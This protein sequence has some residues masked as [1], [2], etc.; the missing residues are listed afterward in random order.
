MSFDR[1]WK[2][3]I[4]QED[5]RLLAHVIEARRRL[6]SGGEDAASVATSVW[7]RNAEVADVLSRRKVDQRQR[8]AAPVGTSIRTNAASSSGRPVSRG[9]AQL[10]AC[11]S[12]SST[13]PSHRGISTVVGGGSTASGLS[14]F[15]ARLEKLEQ[16]LDE[17][18]SERRR[19]YEE[20]DEIRRL[21]LQQKQ[22]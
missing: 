5:K 19:V 2:E 3:R 9:S 21:L 10:S 4:T 13:Q 20:L 14:V 6:A 7:Q 12:S 16:K 18:R 1:A 11:R 22:P 15:S 8:V 17:E